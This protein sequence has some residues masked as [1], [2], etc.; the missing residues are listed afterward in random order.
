MTGRDRSDVQA[1][2]DL[3]DRYDAWYGTPGGRV[4]FDLELAALRPLVGAAT[5]LTLEVGVGS[6]RFASALGMDVGVD[7]AAAPLG[8][9]G[10]RGVRAVR[11]EGEHLP[12]GAGVFGAV[13]FV[14]TLCFVEDPAGVLAEAG[15]VLGSDG[16]LVLGVIPGDSAW[17]RSY[18]EKARAGH[19]FYRHARFYPVAEHRRILARA[20]FRVVDARSTLVQPPSDLP[21]A[22]PV[23]LGALDGAGFVALAAVRSGAT[24]AAGPGD[25]P[26]E[27]RE[28]ATDR[29]AGAV[30]T[31]RATTIGP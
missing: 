5:G 28:M 15:R 16:R 13:L 11:A 12:F 30:T 20:G 29:W 22:E 3:A 8:L 23:R 6:G 1:F 7:A 9:A 18:E 21:A 10:S 2:E 19:P 4:L 26:A 17:G 25:L 24:P 31:R 27:E 14:V